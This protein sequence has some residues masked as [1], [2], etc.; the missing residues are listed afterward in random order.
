MLFRSG[1]YF[2]KYIADCLNESNCNATMAVLLPMACAI[3]GNSQEIKRIK[4]EILENN[5][6][7]AVFSLPNEMFYPGAN[8]TACCM[9]FKIGKKHNDVSNPDTFF[10]Y[11]K[12][13]GFKKKKNVGRIEQLNPSTGK[14]RWVEIEE[15]WMELYRNRMAVKGKSAVKKVAGTSEWLAEAYMETDYSLLR[16]EDFEKTIRE[17]FAYHIVSKE[18]DFNE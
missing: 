13:D 5:T 2:V 8:V 14:S 3:G 15:E 10:G 1:L 18:D 11:C 7:D 6:L 4:K 16:N 9:V 12:D 17:L